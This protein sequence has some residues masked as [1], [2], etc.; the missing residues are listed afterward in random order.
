[1]F[2]AAVLRTNKPRDYTHMIILGLTLW[3]AC[4]HRRHIAFFAVLFG[5]WMPIHLQALLAQADAGRRDTGVAGH[6]APRV[7]IALGALLMVAFSVVGFHLYHQLRQIPVRRDGYPVSAFQ[8][9]ADQQLDGNLVVRFKWAQ[10]AIAA[11]G[12]VPEE[13]GR[14]RVVFDGRF[15]TC[16]PQ[17]IV[18]LYFD[19]AD[20]DRPGRQR[21]PASPPVDSSRI[22]SYREPH[23][24]LIDRLQKNA[25][26]VMQQHQE[27]W[28]LLY[29][30]SLAQLW[31]RTDRYGVATSPDYIPPSQ[32]NI[33]NDL[34]TGVVAWPALP[35]RHSTPVQLAEADIP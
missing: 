3:Q 28:T 25:L 29:Q 22:L 9:M 10:Y 8:Y 7:R 14:M 30:D 32:R 20:G 35:T 19:F 16:Y 1:M 27:D 4:E 24:V 23:L 11:F 2:V 33:S 5:Y 15:R 34:Q 13:Q 12:T 31:G 6:I 17:E 21:S 18:D 26:S